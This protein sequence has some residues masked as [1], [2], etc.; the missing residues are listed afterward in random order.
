MVPANRLL[1]VQRLVV[2]VL[3]HQ[4]LGQQ[5]HVGDAL[6]DDVRGLRCL[7]D[8]FALAASPFSTCMALHAEHP[9]YIVQLLGHVIA[10]ASSPRQRSEDGSY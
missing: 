10:D 9:G 8:G 5:P 7:D 2:G 1:A 4:H 3:G 6:V